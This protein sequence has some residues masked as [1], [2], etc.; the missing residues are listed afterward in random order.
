MRTPFQCRRV[1]AVTDLWPDNCGKHVVEERGEVKA[2]EAT[3]A[4]QRRSSV[5]AVAPAPRRE[6]GR[7]SVM[8]TM[9][10]RR[11]RLRAP[12]KHGR[13]C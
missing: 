7:T 1:S 6:A 3:K 11:S 8:R 13:I 4:L 12:T 5:L 9:T 2:G 10:S